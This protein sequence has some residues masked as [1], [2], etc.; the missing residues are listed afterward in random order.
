MS[1]KLR[2][3]VTF[4]IA[5]LFNGAI[6]VDWLV[7]GSGR[8]EKAAAAFVFHGPENHG[9]SQKDIGD[10]SHK[11][12]D[13]ASFVRRIVS[14]VESPT[15]NAFTLAIAGFGS[16]KS[17]LAVTISELLS[18]D[19]PELRAEILNNISQADAKIGSEVSRACR[20]LGKSLVIT[21]NGMNNSDLSSAL[22]SQVRARVSADGH[23][24]SKLENLRKRFKHASTLLRNLDKRLTDR[25]VKEC[26]AADKDGV[27]SMLESFDEAVYKKA[28]AFLSEIG[29]PLSAVSDETAKDVINITVREFV[30]KDKP[31]N[32]MVVLFDEFGH[33]MEYATA[34]PQIAGD[35]ALQHIFEGVQGNDEKVT[36]VGFVQYELKAY[37]QRL[38][39]EFKNEMN[40]FITRFDNAEKLYLS[41][42]LETLI[43]S[44]LQKKATPSIDVAESRQLRERIATWYPVSQNYSTWADEEIFTRVVVRGCWPLSP[45]AM[46]VL[47][48]LSSSGKYLQQRSA[49]TLLKS[50]IDLHA[51]RECTNALS[52]VC[53]WTTDLQQEFESIEE[54]SAHGMLLQVY[55]AVCAKFDA[56]LSVDEK[57]VLRSIVLLSQTQLRAASREDAD[58]ALSVFSGIDE[59]SLS[60]AMSRLQD[61]YNVIEWD[62]AS[63][64]YEILSDNA[65]KPQFLHLLRQKAQEYD[66]DRQSEVFCGL[67]STIGLL[68]PPE[69]SFGNSH[70][71]ITTEW[72]FEAKPTYW[73]RFLLT[74]DAISAELEKK[75]EFQTV[76]TAR[77]LMI[78]CY[79]PSSEDIES[80][81]EQARRALQKSAKRKPILLILIQDEPDHNLSKALVDID[82]ISRL[83]SEE[84][85]RFGQLISSHAQKQRRVLDDSIRRALMQR[86]YVT[87]FEDVVPNR[88][89]M[90]ELQLFEAAYPKVLPFPFDGYATPRGNAAK[91]C[92]EFTRRLISSSLSYSDTQTMSVAQRNRAQTV[93]NASWKVFSKRDGS[94]VQKPGNVVVKAIMAD[95]EKKLSLQD[96]LNCADAIKIA[97]AAPY[98]ANLASAGLLWGV[99]I[100]AFQKV[101]QAQCEDAPVSLENIANSAFSGNSLDFGYLKGVTLYRMTGENGAWD[102][103]LS[104]WA[105]CGTYREQ[106]EFADRIES[107]ESSLPIPPALRPQ[108]ALCKSESK[109][110]FDI[111]DAAEEKESECIQKIENGVKSDKLSLIAYGASL[112]QSY[113]KE[114]RK[115]PMWDIARDI[116]PLVT[117]VNEAKIKIAA[118]F[119]TWLA[120]NQPRGSTHQDLADFK[121]DS[122]E[123]MARNLKN[124]ELYDEKE[125][126]LTQV[127]RVCK[128]FEQIV[129][130]REAV[131]KYD[132][133][134]VQ[135]GNVPD[136]TPFLRRDAVS[137]D[138]EKW[139]SLIRACAATMKRVGNQHYFDELASRLV[140]IEG[141]KK[142]IKEVGNAI[143]DRAKAVLNST[144]TIETASDIRDE[145]LDL[146]ALYQGD[147]VNLEE[148]RVARNF[149]N[150][151]IDA[152]ARIDS[153]QNTQSQFDVLVAE[154][155]DD[156]VTRFADEEP[157]WDVEESVG[158]LI[159][160]VSQKRRKASSEWISQVRDR[161]S[162]IEGM[163]LQVAENALREIK[164]PPP[165]FDDEKDKAACDVLIRKLE[166]HLES[167]GVDWLVEKFNQLTP[168][169]QK[170]FL[171][172]I[173]T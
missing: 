158:R 53:L 165:Y 136:Q 89:A 133:W 61:E 47:F 138:A 145:V 98:G 164:N 141:I 81:K 119:P 131:A 117:T 82:I 150:A 56:H 28:H 113:A 21:L 72:R 71:V 166:K 78:H 27:I 13:T 129:Q 26:G 114:L 46:W 37:A 25:L 34:H 118:M 14:R 66:V 20:C 151:F 77:G 29:I 103:L 88:L 106:A 17:H 105:S 126:L 173:R 11:L 16:G 65:S 74:V 70:N 4:D 115:D 152:A 3:A 9:V 68:T 48:Y 139:V 41:S 69:C 149:L 130:A 162:D 163:S 144:L 10:S 57:N 100:Q 121:R 33:Y 109:K 18:T 60:R 148:F 36:F 75:T 8:A 80:I 73:A 108:I 172:Q 49:L 5:R 39:T 2:D 171:K 160:T 167:K 170:L 125:K 44:L 112:L 147:D 161:Y 50:A 156:M 62:S 6:D 159:K 64:S 79:V 23:D 123:R 15:G 76:E 107:L 104:D 12:I 43:S 101:V 134:E 97:C 7:D 127:D 52:P 116:E 32:H 91:D 58:Y 59:A 95:W 120:R 128:S 146:T 96:G 30:G 153:L 24:V 132:A 102:Q 137:K 85:S 92:A 168:A 40:R 93:L 83:S 55:N 99:F 54:D 45:V 19:D 31:Y 169:G 110:A 94:V 42:N 51:D 90:M 124:L 86:N 140:R 63:R 22:L 35:G 84:K 67:A 142:R 111:I 135:N 157:P 143:N 154:T 38:P 1:I 155:K 122:E 87:P